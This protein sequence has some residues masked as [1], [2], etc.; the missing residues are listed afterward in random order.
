M[1]WNREPLLYLDLLAVLVIASTST[2]GMIFLAA[3]GS[4]AKPKVRLLLVAVPFVGLAAT[5][6]FDP[7]VYFLL[8]GLV[9]WLGWQLWHWSEHLARPAVGDP[10]PYWSRRFSL[11]SFLASVL[12]AALFLFV[13]LA[14]ALASAADYKFVAT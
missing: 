7:V 12:M 4:R 2:M 8:Q 14:L 9:V 10:V 13:V 1:L 11:A 6:A 5:R 3:L